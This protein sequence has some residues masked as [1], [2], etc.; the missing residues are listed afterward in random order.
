V[1]LGRQGW[2]YFI[3]AG[4]ALFSGI[5]VTW[6]VP[7]TRGK[8]DVDEVSGRLGRLIDV[9]VQDKR[10]WRWLGYY[11]SRFRGSFITKS[12]VFLLSLFFDAPI[13]TL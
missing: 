10:A 12:K 6:Q 13:V 5:F 11:T 1:V 8:K 2:V 7:E 3:F 9:Y 4:L